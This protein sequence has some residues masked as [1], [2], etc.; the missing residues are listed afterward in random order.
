MGSKE[1]VQSMLD[2][3]LQL[4]PYSYLQKRLTELTDKLAEARINL[5]LDMT[6]SNDMVTAAHGAGGSKSTAC[7]AMAAGTPKWTPSQHFG[8]RRR[9]WTPENRLITLRQIEDD[10]E[11]SLRRT[12][13][14]K[15]TGVRLATR[16]L[17]GQDRH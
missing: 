15:P 9:F 13:R 10:I 3:D 6:L 11:T 16:S 5:V 8:K 2:K 17:R 14:Q 4:Q 1:Y 7:V 12:G